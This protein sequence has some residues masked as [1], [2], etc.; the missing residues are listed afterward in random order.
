MYNRRAIV[1]I[2]ILSVQTLFGCANSEAQSNVADSAQNK[3]QLLIDSVSPILWQHN[4][5]LYRFR[6]LQFKERT[7]ALDLQNKEEE[8]KQLT[9]FDFTN[10]C[11]LDSAQKKKFSD[12]LKARLTNI[13]S[14]Y[15][16]I[17]EI[18]NNQKQILVELNQ[19]TELIDKNKLAFV[20]IK[21]IVTNAT[22]GIKNSLSVRING[23]NYRLYFVDGSTNEVI[24]HHSKAG[25]PSTIKNTLASY[26]EK[27]IVPLM[28]TNGGMYMPD[29]QPQGLL[30]D[31]FK[32]YKPI[33]T[34]SQKGSLNFYLQPNGV[35]VID[36]IGRFK[37]LSTNN[38]YNQY[39]NKE[40][41]VKYATQSGPML[42]NADT[43]NSN[44][45]YGSTNVNIRSGVGTISSSRALFIISDNPVNFYDFAVIFRDIFSCS[46]ALYL[47]GAISKMYI[48]HSNK[49]LLEVSRNDGHFGPMISIIDKRSN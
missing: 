34:G 47:D 24:I 33:D 23:V 40:T 20:K 44:F 31:N 32:K 48:K 7:V 10:Y 21:Q 11:S 27:S 12:S 37:I 28:I 15:N 22:S 41:S 17:T 30:I 8:Y 3:I 39:S 38:Y 9:Q 19:V 4:E 14:S 6:Q 45:S 35:F 13:I 5:N 29:Y 42:I 25:E 36:S 26:Q 2:L 49:D 46:N 43:I 18:K 1:V 16:I